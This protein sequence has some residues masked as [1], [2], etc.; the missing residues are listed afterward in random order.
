[1][2]IKLSGN[3]EIAEVQVREALAK[4]GVTMVRDCD[5]QEYMVHKANE[6]IDGPSMVCTFGLRDTLY[7][8]LRIMRGFPRKE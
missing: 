4:V 1:M 2:K 8:G 7:Q 6:T 5:F 3:V